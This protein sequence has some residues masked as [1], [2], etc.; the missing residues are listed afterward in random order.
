MLLSEYQLK[1]SNEVYDM[2]L[3][4]LGDSITEGYPFGHQ[5]SW[6]EYLAQDLNCEILNQGINGD[7]TRGMLE[8]FERDVLAYLPTH[9]IILGGANDAYEA[10]PVNQVSKNFSEMI[11]AC[12]QRSIKPI[13]GLPTPSLL[14]EEEQFLIDY[15]KWLV[16]Y[17]QERTISIIDFYTPFLSRIQDGQAS[18]LFIDEV[19]PSIGGY[20]LMGEVASLAFKNWKLT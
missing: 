2:K 11:E 14:L 10:I 5:E 17:A 6:V 20:A 9:V 1:I 12:E 18:Q 19:H 7:F 4:A 8:R 15:R 13:L 16:D 3:V